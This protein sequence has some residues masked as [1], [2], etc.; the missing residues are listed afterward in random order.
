MNILF[1]GF[2]CS[3]LYS[4]IYGNIFVLQFLE[5]I[6]RLNSP[7][8]PYDMYE[9]HANDNEYMNS[10]THTHIQK[11]LSQSDFGSIKYKQLAAYLTTTATHSTDTRWQ[12]S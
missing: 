1:R 4:E 7:C 10:R 2:L 9:E 11:K 3:L 8:L 6:S 5:V 12:K